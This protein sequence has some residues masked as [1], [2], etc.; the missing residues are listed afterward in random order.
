MPKK[1]IDA[2]TGKPVTRETVAER[3]APKSYLAVITGPYD[4][5][6][7]YRAPDKDEAAKRCLKV[8]RADFKHILGTLKK[9]TEVSVPIYDVTGIDA[10][11]GAE[12][13]FEPATEERARRRLPILETIKLI[14]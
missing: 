9:G 13:V 11:V 12:G 10:E 14:A 4:A 3:F 1:I 8:F 5:G 7:Y 2:R 6:S